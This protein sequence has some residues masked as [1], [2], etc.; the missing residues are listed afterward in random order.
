MRFAASGSLAFATQA[1]PDIPPTP[2]P[3]QPEA[4]P[5]I[6]DNQPPLE[7]PPSSP[8]VEPV[9]PAR[10]MVLSSAGRC[11]ALGRGRTLSVATA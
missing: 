11:S 9:T 1:D 4:P 10:G 6:P 7:V 5:A 8:P 2:R 3:E